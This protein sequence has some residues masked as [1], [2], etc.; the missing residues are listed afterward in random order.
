MKLRRIISLQ[1]GLSLVLLATAV[2][3]QTEAEVK[4]N[5]TKTEQA[6]AM[7]DGVKL[8]TSIY[9]PKDKSKKYPIMLSRT[10]YSVAPYGPNDYKTSVGPSLLFQKERYIFVYQD[11]R[12]K[13]MSEGAYVNM[14]PHI[15][16]GVIKSRTGG[17]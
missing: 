13:F 4:A 17:Y 16:G 14:R 1:F 9:V 11:V 5:Y 8:F 12:G 10:P 6:I 2:Q 15:E 3:A 7:R